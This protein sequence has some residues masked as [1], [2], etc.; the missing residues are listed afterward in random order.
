MKIYIHVNATDNEDLEKDIKIISIEWQES[1]TSYSFTN[2]SSKFKIN[3]DEGYSP[4]GYIVASVLPTYEVYGCN[5]DEY[6]IRIKVVDQDG[7]TSSLWY[8]YNAFTVSARWVEIHDVTLQSTEIYRGGT[9]YITLNASDSLQ[10]ES[11][12]R[13]YYR[14]RKKG[15]LQWTEEVVPISYYN[16]LQGYWQIS[17]TPGLSWDDNKLGEYEFGIRVKNNIPHI[18]DDYYTEVLGTITVFNNVPEAIGLGFYGAPTVERGNKVTIYGEGSDIEKSVVNLTPIFEYSYDNRKTWENEFLD[19]P[20]YNTSYN[21]WRVNFTPAS[22]AHLGN[23]DFRVK[24]D[25]SLNCSEFLEKENLLEVMNAVPK[26]ILFNV[27]KN[28]TFRTNWVILRADV[29]DGDQDISTLTPNFQYQG[30]NDYNWVNH[31]NS[32]YFGYAYVRYNRWVINFIPPSYADIGN[33]SFRVQFTDRFGDTSEPYDIINALKV[34]NSPPEV[35][36]EFPRSGSYN[37]PI[38]TFNAFRT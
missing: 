12:L 37:S 26:V 8:V 22:R 5:V 15:T 21:H 17:F 18:S 31:L 38:I 6:D 16:S 2:N 13:V 28:A 35:E 10:D 14:Y 11:E 7:N 1:Y 36:L 3:L 32:E 29:Y 24:F 4:D 23:Y 9:T 20:F 34:K 30:P 25:D 27:A 33:Y 19:I